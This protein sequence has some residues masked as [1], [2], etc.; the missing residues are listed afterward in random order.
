[1]LAAMPTK[2]DGTVLRSVCTVGV[3]MPANPPAFFVCILMSCFKHN[4]CVGGGVTSI[5][6]IPGVVDLIVLWLKW[7]LTHL[8]HINL[9]PAGVGVG[10]PNDTPPPT[11]PARVLQPCMHPQN[12]ALNAGH[13]HSQQLLVTLTT[14]TTL[15]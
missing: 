12:T 8:I 13:T 1:M 15:Q 5:A 3:L 10:A 14:S 9:D 7:I 11:R 4:V 6:S 2:I